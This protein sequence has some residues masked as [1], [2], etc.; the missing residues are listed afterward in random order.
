MDRKRSRGPTLPMASDP[1]ADPYRRDVATPEDYADALR[2]DDSTPLRADIW[3]EWQDKPHRVAWELCDQWQKWR[4]AME[5][6]RAEIHRLRAVDTNLRESIERIEQE[7]R[8]QTSREAREERL[9]EALAE[10][11]HD[12]WS[13]WMQ[14]LARRC[15]E[16]VVAA[17]DPLME[18]WIFERA[19]VRRWTRQMRMPYEVLSEEERDTDRAEADRILEII[20]NHEGDHGSR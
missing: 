1:V 4:E 6:A 15:V 7:A 20:R 3:A 16:L 10:Y 11:A 17:D 5:A 9:R 13:R 19:D 18:Q 8:Q 2:G 14:H 12:A